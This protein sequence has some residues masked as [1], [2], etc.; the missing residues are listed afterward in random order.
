[1][2]LDNLNR[3]IYFL[4]VSLQLGQ[5][6]GKGNCDLWSKLPAAQRMVV[7]PYQPLMFSV[8][9]NAEIVSDTSTPEQ[10][11]TITKY[12]ALL[13]TSASSKS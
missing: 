2:T 6:N 7:L 11:T 13:F 12:E 8:C 1:M 9:N 10:T 4:G 5:T 3:P